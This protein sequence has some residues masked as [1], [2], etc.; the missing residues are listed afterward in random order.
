MFT[1]FQ[2]KLVAHGTLILLI[3]MLSGIGLL[4][5]LIGGLELWPGHI[6][7][8]DMP[9]NPSAWARTHV[10]GLL[11]ALLIFVIAL[12]LP[13]LGFAESRARLVG[14]LIVGTGWANTLFYWA[15]MFTPNRALT[16]GDNRLG[17]S[18]WAAVVGLMPALIFVLLSLFA[19]ALIALQAWRSPR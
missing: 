18:N 9:G 11:N 8:F 4:A 5:S 15:A 6:M 10:G 14:T 3:A 16:F 7:A 13:G 2:R 1:S 19:V 12:L 17:A